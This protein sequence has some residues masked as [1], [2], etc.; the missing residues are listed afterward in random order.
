[1]IELQF[2]LASHRI[3]IDKVPRDTWT[4]S[5]HHLLR[6]QPSWLSRSELGHSMAKSWWSKTQNSNSK[7]VLRTEDILRIAT[8][9]WCDMIGTMT[10]TTAQ[11]ATKR[12]EDI[13]RIATLLWCD[14]IRTMT[15]TTAQAAAKPSLNKPGRPCPIRIRCWK[16]W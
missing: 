14:M 16:P 2:F 9:L 7:D 15:K 3:S 1:M 10:K 5:L 12:T 6:I 8:L 4:L 11:A 13:L